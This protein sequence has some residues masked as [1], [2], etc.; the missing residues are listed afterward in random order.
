V[1]ARL[2]EEERVK[3]QQLK[4]NFDQMELQVLGA[5]ALMQNTNAVLQ[6]KYGLPPRF[7]IQVDT[8]N[9]VEVTEDAQVPGV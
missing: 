7:H 9:I 8:G 6:E 2:T 5:I 3:Y 1:L 4:H